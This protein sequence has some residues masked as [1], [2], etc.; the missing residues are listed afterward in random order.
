MKNYF[1]KIFSYLTKLSLIFFAYFIIIL[2]YK[3]IITTMLLIYLFYLIQY[4]LLLFKVFFLNKKCVI[5][6]PA[7][8]HKND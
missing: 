2:N 7:F 3:S 8:S 6:A 4:F 5:N 1:F